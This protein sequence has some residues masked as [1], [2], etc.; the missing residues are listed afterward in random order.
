MLSTIS[1]NVKSQSSDTAWG[2]DK[3]KG[4]SVFKG[5]KISV[6]GYTNSGIFFDDE[7]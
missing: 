5:K 2:V 3:Y 7:S 4:K 6:Q 1:D